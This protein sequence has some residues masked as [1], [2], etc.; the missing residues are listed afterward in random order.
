M[1]AVPAKRSSTAARHAR[2][3]PAAARPVGVIV[4]TVVAA[5]MFLSACG[6]DGGGSS[7]AG[8]VN[9]VNQMCRQ[10]AAMRRTLVPSSSAT[11][12]ELVD[13]LKQAVA[14]DQQLQQRI[15]GL[16]PP[17]GDAPTIRQLLSL[18]EQS[19]QVTLQLADAI[20]RQ[21]ISTMNA[22][23]PKLTDLGNQTQE[24]ANRYG[25]SGCTQKV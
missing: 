10:S 4:A 7:R 8:Y 5:A 11:P 21:N 2:V 16:S 3:G 19:D 22:L 24:L 23:Y 1:T 17:P 14:V 9:R 13:A 15:T 25:L 18:M 12:Q 20:Q 6:G